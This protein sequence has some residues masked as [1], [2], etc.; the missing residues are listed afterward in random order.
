MPATALPASGDPSGAN[1]TRTCDARGMAEIHRMFRAGFGEGPALVGG[2]ADSDAAQAEI[3]GDYLAMLSVGLHAHHEGEDTLLW[4]RLE[5]RAPSCTAHVER[6]KQQHAEMLVHLA[7][8]DASLPAWR[9]GGRATD[10]ASVTTALAGINAALAVHL[11]DEETNIVPVMETV[12]APRDVDALAEHGRRATPKGKVFI[13]LGTI[14]DAQPDGGAEWQR[15][16]LQ[17][18]LRLIWRVVGKQR[19]ERYRAA[20]VR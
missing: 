14:L 4:D 11:P 12:L 20:L 17:A 15:E 16:H 19:Y 2:V 18:P 7:K 5:N 10:A 3:V 9:A 8:L 13:Q 1:R 6:M